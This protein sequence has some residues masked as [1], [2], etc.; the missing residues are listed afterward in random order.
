MVVVMAVV[1][2]TAVGVVVTEVM[3]EE[4]EGRGG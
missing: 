4:L 1:V 2:V 3:A